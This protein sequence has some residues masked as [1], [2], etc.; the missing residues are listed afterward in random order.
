MTDLTPLE[1]ER[2]TTI[3]RMTSLR[4]NVRPLFILRLELH[5]CIS[6]VCLFDGE[7]LWGIPWPIHTTGVPA[8]SHATSDVNEARTLEAEAEAGT[9]EAEAEAEAKT[10]EAEAEAGYFGLEAEAGFE[11]GLSHKSKKKFVIHIKI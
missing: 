8:E 1:P 4:I 2:M 5:H 9:L 3:F 10:L 6:F 11:A 7:E